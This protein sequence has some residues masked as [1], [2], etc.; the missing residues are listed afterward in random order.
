L[1]NKK[2]PQLRGTDKINKWK[3]KRVKAHFDSSFP[4]ESGL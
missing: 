1:D 3:Y 4:S 2:V